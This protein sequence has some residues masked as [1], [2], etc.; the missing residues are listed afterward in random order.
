MVKER[1]KAHAARPMRVLPQSCPDCTGVLHA[2]EEGSPQLERC[3]WSAAVLLEQM[4]D[5]YQQLFKEMPRT[6]GG[7]KAVQRRITEVK[8]QC[9]V[10]REMM[11]NTHVA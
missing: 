5:A 2:D 4:E 3:L 9:L 11:E 6:P 10:I 7:R 1:T 8:Q